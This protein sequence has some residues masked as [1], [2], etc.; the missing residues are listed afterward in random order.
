M[1]GGRYVAILEEDS[2]SRDPACVQLCSI[3]RTSLCCHQLITLLI[4][5]L[6]RLE[7]KL[8]GFEITTGIDIFIFY[9]PEFPSQNTQVT[10]VIPCVV[11]EGACLVGLNLDTISSDLTI[12]KISDCTP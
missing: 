9:N 5:V 4:I 2:Q 7:T 3:S 6:L 11:G 8:V 1:T 10:I 12:L